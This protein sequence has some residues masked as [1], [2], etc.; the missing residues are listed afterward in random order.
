MKSS[1]KLKRPIQKQ[2]E[3]EFEFD[4]DARVRFLAVEARDEED[5]AA[6]FEDAIISA[7]RLLNLQI[8]VES[9]R[10]D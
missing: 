6:M 5:A 10:P 4:V 1:M 2:E 3:R 8:D 7:G 9:Y